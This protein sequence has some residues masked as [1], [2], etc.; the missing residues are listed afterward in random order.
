[1]KRPRLKIVFT[2]YGGQGVLTASQ[3]LGRAAAEAGCDVMVGQLHGMSQRG[4]SV[5]STVLIG[6][7]LSAHVAEGEADVVLGFEPLETLRSLPCMSDRTLV[8]MNIDRCMPQ[9]LARS[10]APYPDLEGLL[11]RI[12]AVAG[13]LILIDGPEIVRRAGAARTLNVALLGA[14]AGA[15]VLPFHEQALWRAVEQKSPERF[16]EANRRA[17]ELGR[18][19]ACACSPEVRG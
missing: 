10:G 7:G 9:P 18:Q 15:R 19:A 8:L 12:R 5:E 1:M 16:R 4:G 3:I 17:F 6:P 11:E 13:E 14:L 2:G